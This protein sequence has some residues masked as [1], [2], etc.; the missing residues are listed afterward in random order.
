MNG[1]NK[2]YQGKKKQVEYLMNK[3]KFNQWIW[4]K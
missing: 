4:K 3:Y 2:L 1:V